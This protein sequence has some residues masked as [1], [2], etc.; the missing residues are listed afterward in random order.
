[1]SRYMIHEESKFLTFNSINF[2]LIVMSIISDILNLKK[3]LLYININDGNYFNSLYLF[4]S[5]M[6]RYKSCKTCCVPL[7]SQHNCLQTL[8]QMYG[9][10]SKKVERRNCYCINMDMHTL[11]SIV[12]T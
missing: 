12:S 4:C 5:Y 7:L 11:K 3:C 8:A 10:I 2:H 1:M 9:M 6:N